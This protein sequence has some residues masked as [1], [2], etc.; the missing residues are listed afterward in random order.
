MKDKYFSVYNDLD[1]LVEADIHCEG[2]SAEVF[3]DWTLFGLHDDYEICM[4]IHPEGYQYVI[5][6]WNRLTQDMNVATY[7]IMFVG[8]LAG[9]DDP[10]ITML[11]DLCFN[12]EYLQAGLDLIEKWRLH[13]LQEI[14][15]KTNE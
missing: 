8:R 14:E 1:K 6:E 12:F 10:H 4:F 15:A 3:K 13:N 5:C 7:T 9:Y 2:I 11:D